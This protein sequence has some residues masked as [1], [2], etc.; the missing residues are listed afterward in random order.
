MLPSPAAG[1]KHGA[2]KMNKPSIDGTMT[3]VGWQ[4]MLQARP[5]QNRA[6]K[7]E[8]GVN[9]AVRL[10]VKKRKPKF[11][12]PPLSWLI[13][14]R[15]SKRY[16]LDKLGEC[17][18]KLCDGKRRVEDVIDSFAGEFHLSF[19]EARVAVTSYLKA[20]VQRGAVVL[21]LNHEEYKL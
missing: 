17:V 14:P 3:R 19:H 13:R 10:T 8:T 18:W 12:I 16:E 20:L 11:L 4:S 2:T 1:L 5:M 21:I 6:A 9:G 15:L 7:Q